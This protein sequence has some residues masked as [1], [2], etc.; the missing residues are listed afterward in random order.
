MD[1]VQH[2]DPFLG[3]GAIDLPD[4]A[5]IAATW[6]FIKAQTGNTHPG[7]CSPF[8]MV[9]ACACSG[10]YVTGYG[11]NAPNTHGRPPQRFSDYTATGFSHF[12]HSGTGAIGT[13]YNYA[14]TAPFTGALPPRGTRWNLATRQRLSRFIRR[15]PRSSFLSASSPA[16][17]KRCSVVVASSTA[18]SSA[19]ARCRWMRLR[20]IV[21]M[22]FW[23]HWNR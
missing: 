9:S 20:R 12:H 2:I 14:L 5:G 22:T 4:P 6:F 8:G 23:R 17:I 21:S 10:A 1:A 18:R 15:W 7:A 16:V 3:N 11:L 13:Y 19:T